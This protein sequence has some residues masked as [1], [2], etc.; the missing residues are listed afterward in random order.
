[1]GRPKGSLNRRTR[2]ALSA[3]EEARFDERADKTIDRLLKLSID[4]RKSDA[5][6]IQAANVVLP[7]LRP[8]RS[9]V[10]V[11]SNSQPLETE[12]QL[13]AQLQALL[14]QHPELVQLLATA[15]SEGNAKADPIT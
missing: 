9:A 12:E 6:R 11:N 4:T 1:M 8:K 14:K 3:A 5:V 10:E 2:A 15:S 13:L 7:Y